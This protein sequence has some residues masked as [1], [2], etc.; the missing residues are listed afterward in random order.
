M[1]ISAQSSL[2]VQNC[3]EANKPSFDVTSSSELFLPLQTEGF[4]L[5]E[6]SLV[7]CKDKPENMDTVEKSRDENWR[8]KWRVTWPDT[9]GLLS[10]IK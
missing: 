3:V 4:F 1:V 6:D 5:G 9:A 8:G 2:K 7:F 10:H